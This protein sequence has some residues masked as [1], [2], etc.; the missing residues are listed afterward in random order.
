MAKRL[1]I[2]KTYSFIILVLFSYQANSQS[3]IIF[4]RSLGGLNTGE[5]LDLMIYDTQTKKTSLLLKGSVSRRGEHDA[6]TSP[7]NSKIIFNT[8]RFNGWK[9]GVGDFHDGAISN[10]KKLTN[11]SNYEY[12]PKYSPNG[13]K[14]AYQEYNW[15]TGDSDIFITD[16]NGNNAIHFIKSKGPDHCPDWT[17]DN[18]S[19]VFASAKEDNFNIF[20]KLI[21]DNISKKLT[22][23]SG[24]NFAPSVSKISNKIAFLSSKS[25]KIELCVMDIDG[26]NL[27]NLTPN[28][29]TDTFKSEGYWAYKTSWSPDGKQIV[30]SVLINGDFELFIVNNDGTGLTQI[31]DNSD[32]DIT[33]FWMN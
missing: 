13:L 9:L 5:T 3:K 22:E 11:R 28:L 8:Y 27:K 7:D 29:K 20:I 4:S 2:E 18:K 16:K 14:V 32:T 23:N 12:N 33:P 30:F 25:R 15:G 6:V 1:K 10:V 17:N 26:N 24:D 19:I 31:T 21:N